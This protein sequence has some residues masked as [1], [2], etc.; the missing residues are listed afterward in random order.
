MKTP[1][2]HA[3]YRGLTVLLCAAA[4]LLLGAWLALETGPKPCNVDD[5]TGCS[6]VG[7]LAV[8]AFIFLLPVTA[9]LALVLGLPWV[10]DLLRRGR[11]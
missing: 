10:R 2:R 3:R 5:F 7:E 8:F 11:T 4:A 9:G 1:S 6:A